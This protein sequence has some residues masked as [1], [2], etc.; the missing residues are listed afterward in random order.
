[1][2]SNPRE[3]QVADQRVEPVGERGMIDAARSQIGFR[4]RKI[5]LYFVKGRFRRGSS[6][7]RC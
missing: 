5:G 6:A 7:A 1:M 4:V 2:T 3:H